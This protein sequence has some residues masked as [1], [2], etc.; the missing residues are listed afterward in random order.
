MLRC[1]CFNLGYLKMER[2][3][4]LRSGTSIGNPTRKC[5]NRLLTC[6]KTFSFLLLTGY[7]NRKLP[8]NV[9]KIEKFF[10]FFN[11]AILDINTDYDYFFRD[12][13]SNVCTL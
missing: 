13:I 5:I 6:I 1:L 7:T 11:H 10:P 4:V 9:E 12:L 3:I 8:Q 2:N